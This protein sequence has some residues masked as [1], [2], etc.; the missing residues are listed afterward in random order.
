MAN[1]WFSEAWANPKFKQFASEGLQDLGYGLSNSTNVGNAF[2]A[3]TRR[4]QEMQPYRDMRGDKQAEMAQQSEQ[5]N[6]TKA[7]LTSKGWDDLVPL[8]DAGQANIALQEAMAR[9]Q[10]GYGQVASPKPMEIN[11]QLVDP[12]TGQVIGDY[13]D[14]Q[15]GMGNAPS[16]YQWGEGGN[17]AF[18]PGGPADPATAANKPPTEGQRRLEMLSTVIEPELQRVETNWAELANGANQA[19]NTEIPFIGGRP[20]R[21]LSS[22]G[23]QQATEA[24]GTIAQSYLYSVSG[25]A[26]PVEE[27][28]KL[29]D[30]V[31]PK[32][33]E[34]QASINDKLLRIKEMAAAVKA[35][36][37]GQQAAPQQ[38]PREYTF[39]PATGRLE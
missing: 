32:P 5:T 31:T 33:F 17:L 34:S 27:V 11:G 16:G 19:A 15:S 12:V 25:A 9:S 22:P 39:N 7:Y 21:A 14:P 8:I 4:T 23:Y 20:G 26:A 3:A 10:P 24:L 2:G 1:E 35:A 30:S 18:I 28:R 6:A 36:A 37:G 29:V 38:A 13:R